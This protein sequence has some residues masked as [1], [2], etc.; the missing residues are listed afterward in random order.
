MNCQNFESLVGDLARGVPLEARSRAEA[1]AHETSCARCA[2]RLEDE[3]AL[4]AG[5]RGLAG[6]AAAAAAPPRVE[7]H[8]LAAFRAQ[9][10]PRAGESAEA[11]TAHEVVAPAGP[12][13][14]KVVALASHASRRR[15]T[16]V[17]A[18][19]AAAAAAAAVALFALVAPRRPAPPAGAGAPVATLTPRVTPPSLVSAPP[20]AD[21][22]GVRDDVGAGVVA[23]TNTVTTHPP[24][25]AAPRPHGHAL[26]RPA[27]Y[28][29]AAGRAARPARAFE[30]G[31]EEI[32]T[33]FIALTQDARFAVSE[34][35]QVVRVELPRTALQRF[36]LPMDVE[37][38]GGRVKADVLLGHDG[39]AR[40]I[41]FVR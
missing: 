10:T 15:W 24:R 16:W 1:R 36:G 19:G 29:N 34:G 17:R 4:S 39:V 33:D 5:L 31:D 25:A 37:R 8:L 23:G 20:S 28:R 2:A 30:P 14:R 27:G 3:R 38:A 12:A 9:A 40:A 21:V 7:A 35:G 26:A 18:V 6:S 13:A 22:G 11:P 32:A 41:R